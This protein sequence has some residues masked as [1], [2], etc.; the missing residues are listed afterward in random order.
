MAEVS[1]SINKKTVLDDDNFDRL[2]EKIN[3]N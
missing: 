2:E 3:E 1:F